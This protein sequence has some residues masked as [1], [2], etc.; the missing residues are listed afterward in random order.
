MSFE[1]L[2]RTERHILSSGSVYELLRRS[3]E[4][5]F[6]AH[7]FHAGLIYDAHFAD[8]L[9]GVFR[10]YIDKA[11]ACGLSIAVGTATWRASEERIRASAFSDRAVN[12][13]NVRFLNDIRNS[14]ADVKSSD[15][16]RV[17]SITC[18]HPRFPHFPR[19][20]GLRWRWPGQA[21]H[22]PSASWS[23]A[24]VACWMAQS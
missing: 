21:C 22:M 8:V 3:P 16:R 1:N 11:V 5:V 12:E 2:L 19:L 14:Y 9:A 6:D 13:D 7:I 4:V 10:A 18:R 17:M 20:R 23:T 24:P 15:W